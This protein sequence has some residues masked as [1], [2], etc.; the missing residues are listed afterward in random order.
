MEM[1]LQQLQQIMNSVAL[2]ELDKPT[3][4]F[5]GDIFWSIDVMECYQKDQLCEDAVVY[6]DA[7]G[8]TLRQA[9]I[10]YLELKRLVEDIRW[11]ASASLSIQRFYQTEEAVHPG[12][13]IRLNCS[14]AYLGTFLRVACDRNL[15]E[16][17]NVSELCRWVSVNFCTT[18]QAQ[19]SPHSIRNHF[20]NPASE[21]MEQVMQELQVWG[22]YL[23]KLSQ[24]KSPISSI[25]S[26][27]FM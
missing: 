27:T 21:A 11:L 20:D 3:G 6:V 23:V 10:Y 24:H 13:K 18:R 17:A 16:V 1:I 26:T 4:L 5:N 2:E 7:M 19:L 9:L 12:N 25:K 8:Q 15:I 14:V 22:K